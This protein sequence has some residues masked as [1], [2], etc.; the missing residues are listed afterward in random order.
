[1]K[2]YE[3]TKMSTMWTTDNLKSKVERF[4]NDVNSQGYKIV[5]VSFGVNLWWMPTAYITLEKEIE[6]LNS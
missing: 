4:L 6:E 2:K 3:I 1:M 5:S